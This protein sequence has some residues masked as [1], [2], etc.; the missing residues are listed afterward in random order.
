MV[1]AVQWYRKAAEQ[2]DA[3]AQYKLGL[4]YQ[5]GRGVG[6]DEGEAE[7]WQDKA[8]EIWRKNAEDAPVVS[9]AEDAET[10]FNLGMNY[11]RGEGV[12]QDYIEAI[13]WFRK[14]ADQGFAEAQY[15]L[16]RCYE[17]IVFAFND[18][19]PPDAPL[20]GDSSLLPY[21]KKTIHYAIA[22]VMEDYRTKRENTTNQTLREEY[23]KIIQTFSYLLTRL[24]HDWQEIPPEDK[25]AIA[26]LGRFDSF[27]DWAL[28]LKLKYLDDE[29]ASIEACDMTI[30]VMKD[31]IDRE[32]NVANF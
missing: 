31:R 9:D 7:K 26:K 4:C 3:D 32:K 1:E 15:N 28:P 21:P 8:R 23:D 18:F 24:A 5:D 12:P 17:K 29:R 27:P 22:A 13:K 19:L 14:A 25:A 6:K 10:S 16:T 30:Q 2:G 20:I 11:Y